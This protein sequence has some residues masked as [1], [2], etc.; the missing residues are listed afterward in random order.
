MADCDT[1]N[2]EIERRQCI[3]LNERKIAS[4]FTCFL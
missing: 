4:C 1:L 3:W 2:T